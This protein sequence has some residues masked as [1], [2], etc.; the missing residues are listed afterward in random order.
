MVQQAAF[1]QIPDVVKGVSARLS[2][3]CMYV[4]TW[5]WCSSLCIFTRLF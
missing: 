4:L 3:G 2:T 5:G 1:S